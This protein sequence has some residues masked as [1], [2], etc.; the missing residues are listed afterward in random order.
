[1]KKQETDKERKYNTITSLFWTNVP[2]KTQCAK[3]GATDLRVLL[4]WS[5]KYEYNSW[6]LN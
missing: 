6:M 2:G 3:T 5:S 1:M 4:L